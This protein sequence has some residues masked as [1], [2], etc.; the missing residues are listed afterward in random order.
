M[1]TAELMTLIVML[2]AIII[3]AFWYGVNDIK[4]N[5][6]VSKPYSVYKLERP[7]KHVCIYVFGGLN[8][9]T[10]FSDW[11]SS[12]ERCPDLKEQK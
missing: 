10:S 7:G 1:K 12:F 5:A 4:L 11:T 8:G 3:G 2:V 6:Q 9:L